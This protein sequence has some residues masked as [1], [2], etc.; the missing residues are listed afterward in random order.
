[1]EAEAGEDC[2]VILCGEDVISPP[3][4]HKFTQTSSFLD[5]VI[6]LLAEATWL[7]L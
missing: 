3:R 6:T 7:L 2:V 5:S 4:A 1:M